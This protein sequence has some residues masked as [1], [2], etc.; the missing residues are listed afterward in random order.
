MKISNK[1]NSNS[2]GKKKVMIISSKKKRDQNSLVLIAE[3][4]TF[5]Y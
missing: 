1:M 3:K 5:R 4:L 2:K